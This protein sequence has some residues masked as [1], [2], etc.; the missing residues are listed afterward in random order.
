MNSEKLDYIRLSSL[1]DGHYIPS[2]KKTKGSL[3]LDMIAM[4]PEMVIYRPRK[5]I[6]FICVPWTSE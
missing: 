6:I 1:S 2:P 4:P 3:E 5:G